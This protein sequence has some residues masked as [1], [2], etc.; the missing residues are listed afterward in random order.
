[1]ISKKKIWKLCSVITRLLEY[2]LLLTSDETRRH[3]SC[4]D[5]NFQ[6][7]A[8]DTSQLNTVLST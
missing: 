8:V 1:M 6:E 2:G 4:N 3:N 7:Y 5:R